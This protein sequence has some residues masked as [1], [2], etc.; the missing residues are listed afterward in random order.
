MK[1]ILLV[2]ATSAEIMPLLRHYHLDDI[3][4][5]KSI[6][7]QKEKYSLQLLVTGVG[8]VNT[9][10]HLT[11]HLGTFRPDLILNAG[12]AGSFTEK[13]A[14]GAVV[15]IGE[16]F[17][18]DMGAEDDDKFLSVDELGLGTSEVKDEKSNEFSTPTLSRIPLVRA[19]TVNRVHGNEKSIQ[20]IRERLQPDI[21]TMEGAAFSLVCKNEGVR[22]LHLRCI[23]NKVERR[24]RNSWNIPLAV[25]RLNE[26]LLELIP[27]LV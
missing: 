24:N 4:I 12:I 26:F 11:K 9:A 2:A 20:A 18:A 15:R 13:I 3:S 22:Q 17:F 16:D 19:I 27:E 10:Y 23:S 5:G 8:M 7:I 6:A 21:E 25:N 1:K 14:I